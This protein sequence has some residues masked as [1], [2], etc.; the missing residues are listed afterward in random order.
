MSVNH[1]YAIAIANPSSSSPT[2]AI[3]LQPAKQKRLFSHKHSQTS[4]FLPDSDA[5][6]RNSDAFKDQE[7]LVK[8]LIAENNI[9]GLDKSA[10]D[11][12]ARV[13]GTTQASESWLRSAITALQSNHLISN[14]SVDD[15]MQLATKTLESQQQ[16]HENVAVEVDYLSE[17]KRTQSVDEMHETRDKAMK[18]KKGEGLFGFWISRPEGMQ[19]KVRRVNSWERKDDAYGGLM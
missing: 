19:K 1:L 14:F 10:H 11:T 4:I 12:L 2:W 13:D 15:F 7:L 18:K 9:A 17:L 16:H 3:S 5:Q 6:R 8:L